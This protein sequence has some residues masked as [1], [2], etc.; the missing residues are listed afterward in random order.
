MNKKYLKKFTAVFLSLVMVMAFAVPS[1]AKTTKASHNYP[2]IM[3]PGYFC[4]AQDSLIAAVGGNVMGGTYYRDYGK[5]LAKKGITAY[6]PTIAPFSSNWDRA[7]ELY[8][9][10]KGGRVDYGAAHSKAE[11]HARY[12]R[13]YAKGLYPQWDSKHPVDLIGYSMG[14]QTAKILASLLQYGSAAEVEAAG[15]SCSPLF[16]GGKA[17]AVNSITTVCGTNNGTTLADDLLSIVTMFSGNRENTDRVAANLLTFWGILSQGTGFDFVIDTRMDQWGLAR[18]PGMSTLQ[19]IKNILQSNMWKSNDNAFYD[20]STIGAKKLNHK[21]KDNTHCYYFA[22]SAQASRDISD[23][24]K[25]QIFDDNYYLFM[26][27]NAL[28]GNMKTET[29]YGWDDSFYANDCFVNTEFAKAPFNSKYVSYKEGI[30]PTRGVWINMPTLHIGHMYIA[31]L[32]TN[33]TYKMDM[34]DFFTDQIRWVQSLD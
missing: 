3:I 28:I 22:Y 6:E 24:N 1:M 19:Y 21:F 8:A 23:S 29:A 33:L 10:I 11:G 31:G 13:T 17:T 12:G 16:T 32:F 7:C 26:T 34:V 27:F 5:Q 20:M 4:F 18:T 2:V 15:K 25:H 14:A 9:C 30:T